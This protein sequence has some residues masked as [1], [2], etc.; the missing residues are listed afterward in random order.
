MKDAI[1]VNKILTNEFG[2]VAI[3]LTKNN[4]LIYAKIHE[5]NKYIIY[6]EIPQK[7][8]GIITK[9]LIKEGKK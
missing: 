9:Y 5:K 7:D 6:E 1:L 8:K 2:E 3:F 4:K